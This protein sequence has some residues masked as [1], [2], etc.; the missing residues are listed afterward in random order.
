MLSAGEFQ[1]VVTGGGV[2][3]C[4]SE[5]M[6]KRIAGVCGVPLLDGAGGGSHGYT[7][8]GW[9]DPCSCYSGTHHAQRYQE[10]QEVRLS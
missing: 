1:R 4:V 10:W 7:V 9:H 2:S 3:G 8:T 5:Q 6:A